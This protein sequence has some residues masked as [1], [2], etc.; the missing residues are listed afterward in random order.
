MLQKKVITEKAYVAI[1]H[2]QKIL[3]SRSHENFIFSYG[4]NLVIRR[5]IFSFFYPV[6]LIM[7]CTL[8]KS[9]A[10]FLMLKNPVGL[11]ALCNPF[12]SAM[13]GVKRLF[14]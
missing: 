7:H 4:I 2:G 5:S 3:P 10:I 6:L 12:A 8:Q 9:A 11:I 14:M 1:A 13:S